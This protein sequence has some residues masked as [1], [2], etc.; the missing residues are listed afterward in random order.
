MCLESIRNTSEINNRNTKKHKHTN[1]RAFVLRQKESMDYRIDFLEYMIKI[2][3]F[4]AIPFYC[5]VIL[6]LFDVLK[7]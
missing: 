1:L 5:F 3:I 6:P 7:D 2:N 4:K